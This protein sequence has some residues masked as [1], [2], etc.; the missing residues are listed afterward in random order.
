MR[1]LINLIENNQVPKDTDGQEYPA[2]LKDEYEIADY[3]VGLSSDYADE[4]SIVEYFNNSYAKLKLVPIDEIKE[5]RA[6]H[7]IRSSA[8]ER[9]YIKM[10]S[11]IP[12]IVVEGGEIMDGNHRFRVAKKKG[13][14]H[15]WIYDVIWN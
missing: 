15:I 14:T 2:I 12:P 5:G 6:D 4:E 10:S 7:N 8:K 3:I 13:L 1:N 9:K 11:D